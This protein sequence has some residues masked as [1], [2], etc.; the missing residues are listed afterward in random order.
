MLLGLR[1][2]V[3]VWLRRIRCLLARML[4]PLGL[5]MG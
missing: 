5:R 4:V 3:I 2:L 1:F